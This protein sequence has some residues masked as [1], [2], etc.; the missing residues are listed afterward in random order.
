MKIFMYAVM[1]ALTRK[2]NKTF[3]SLPIFILREYV[4]SLSYLYVQ[5]I[6]VFFCYVH[7]CKHLVHPIPFYM[8][9]F[10]ACVQAYT[11]F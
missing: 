10:P 7:K 3:F 1:D 6:L 8:M 4:S 11:N 2:Y 9:P 5:Y